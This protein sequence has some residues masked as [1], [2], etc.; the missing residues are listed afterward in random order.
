MSRS[1]GK[2]LG[3]RGTFMPNGI[4][5]DLAEDLARA[6]DQSPAGRVANQLLYNRPSESG[7]Y[8]GYSGIGYGGLKPEYNTAVEW[9]QYT[10]PTYVV[11]Y[12]QPTQRVWLVQEEPALESGNPGKLAPEE[13]LRTGETNR[14]IMATLANVPLPLLKDLPHG[15]IPS[16]GTDSQVL[17]WRPATDE[18]WEFHRL[19]KFQDGPLKGQWK[20]GAG[21]YQAEV[22]KYRGVAP[23]NTGQVSAS[24]LS[25]GML[26]ITMGD[27]LR[28]LRGGAIEHALGLTLMV[29][30]DEHVAPATNNDHRENPFEKMEDGTTPNPAFGNVDAVPEGSWFV[31]PKA[32]RA[33]DYPS[34]TTPFEK[35]FYEALRKYGFVVHD[36][37]GSVRFKL[38]DP[39]PL[40]TPYSRVSTNPFN[41]NPFYDSYVNEGTTEEQRKGWIDSSLTTLSDVMTGPGN[42]MQNMPWRT[43]ELLTP[44]EA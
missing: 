25:I 44:R 16:A 34:L 17:I 24:K 35:A 30:K 4:Y 38:E 19:C 15:R 26:T 29:T 8:F 2:L 31:F 43:L 39:C 14:A 10:E 20:A 7:K 23:L 36:G 11:P 37:G 18:L 41:G 6:S 1:A 5:R 33:S 27:L 40:F 42:P 32:S 21:H 9:F 3:A 28:V 12:N 22:S 13:E